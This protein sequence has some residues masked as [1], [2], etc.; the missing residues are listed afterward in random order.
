MD[1]CHRFSVSNGVFVLDH[2][3]VRVGVKGTYLC[4]PGFILEGNTVRVCTISNDWSGEPAQCVQP[5]GKNS[6]W[7]ICEIRLLSVRLLIM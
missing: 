3:P 6:K 2:I 7:F 1:S 4:N 5:P